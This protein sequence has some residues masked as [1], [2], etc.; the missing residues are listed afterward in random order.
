MGFDKRVNKI[1]KVK[2]DKWSTETIKQM[3][4]TFSRPAFVSFIQ[5]ENENQKKVS[6]KGTTNKDITVTEDFKTTN[7]FKKTYGADGTII[8]SGTQKATET[9]TFKV[10][11]SGGALQWFPSRV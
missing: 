11:S 3:Q 5:T 4:A 1:V 6:K 7:T 8:Y 9:K 2:K 10:K